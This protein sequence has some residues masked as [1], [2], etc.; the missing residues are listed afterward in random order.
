MECSEK[1]T[2]YQPED[3]DWYCPKCG[4][5]KDIVIDET[6]CEIGMDCDKVHETDFIRCYGTGKNGEACDFDD[7]GKDYVKRLI[8][9]KK[10]VPCKHCKGKGMVKG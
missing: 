1:P 10:L 4:A 3:K 5:T 9:K 6:Y 7:N 8:A 2:K